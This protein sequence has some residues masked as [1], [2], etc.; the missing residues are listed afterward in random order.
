MFRL[1][2]LKAVDNSDHIVKIL[3]KGSIALYMKNSFIPHKKRSFTC[4]HNIPLKKK[5]CHV[6]IVGSDLHD[7]ADL[8]ASFK[9]LVV[10]LNFHNLSWEALG[11]YSGLTHIYLYTPILSNDQFH[12]Y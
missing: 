11:S 6:P 2:Y 5:K 8:E 9:L 12:V 10:A 4:V 1:R 7:F 3:F